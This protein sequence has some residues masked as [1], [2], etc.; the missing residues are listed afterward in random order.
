M[1]RVVFGEYSENC[2]E[3]VFFIWN[4]IWMRFVCI[5]VYIK[6]GTEKS[7]RIYVYKKTRFVDLTNYYNVYCAED[8][9]A[10][11]VARLYIIYI[12]WN[13]VPSCCFSCQF[14]SLLSHP[15]L[16]IQIRSV[17]F[18]FRSPPAQFCPSSVRFGFRRYFTY[19]ILI[20]SL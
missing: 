12:W 9:V 6:Q 13:V 19:I 11:V 20:I 18:H 4:W 10:T 16:C 7:L 17:Y 1:I 14:F 15:I 3:G 8:I 2:V 5:R